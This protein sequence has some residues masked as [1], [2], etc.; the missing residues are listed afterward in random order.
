MK[1]TYRRGAGSIL[2]VVLVMLFIITTITLGRSFYTS[3]I[4]DRTSKNVYGDLGLTLASNILKEG[5]LRLSFLANYSGS[6]SRI[7]ENMRSE[8]EYFTAP[9]PLS[10]LPVSKTMLNEYKGYKLLDDEI[11]VKCLSKHAS[12][13]NLPFSHDSYGLLEL[14]ASIQHLQSGVFREKKEI[15][16]YRITLT[17][18]PVPLSNYTLMIGDGVFLTNGYGVD[19]DANKTIDSAVLRL[20]ELF[21]LLQD[22][23]T[24][25]DEFKKALQDKADSSIPPISGEYEDGA[26]EVSK[27]IDILQQT[28][29]LKPEIMIKDFG[30]ETESDHKTIHYFSPPPQCFYSQEAQINLEDINLPDKVKNRLKLIDENEK[31]LAK[32]A[33]NVKSFIDSKPSN[34]A[35]L[36]NLINDLCQSTLLTAKEYENLLLKDYKNFQDKLIEIGSTSY[37]DYLKAFMQLSKIDLL[38][39]AT[40]VITEEDDGSEQTI[41]EK[42][43]NFLDNRERYNGLIFVQN[44][45]TE[46]VINRKFK[47]RIFLVVEGDIAIEQ[48]TIDNEK[49]DLITIASFRKMTLKGPV[50]ASLI[51]WFSF[52]SIPGVP[53]KGN[54]IFSRLNFIGA[55]PAEVLAGYVTYDPRLGGASGDNED[56]FKKHQYVSISP[57]PLAVDVKRQ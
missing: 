9:I 16:S 8:D 27:S 37:P 15:F 40:A 4:S 14:S 29:L 3:Y 19:N 51:P 41:N 35:P 2:V 47:G 10:S 56:V 11:S 1:S 31:N 13:Q 34:L 26:N 44:P 12:S 32:Y 48:A 6:S 55:T 46:L 20:N 24:K 52:S 43:N 50:E 49:S 39:K 38:R 5:N 21:T 36:P 53:I 45:T 54:L 22:F 28:I 57:F 42:L 18:P 23:A 30:E 7:F 33:A 25:G 17:A